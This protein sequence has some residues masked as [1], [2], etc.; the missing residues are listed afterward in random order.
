MYS[1]KTSYILIILFIMAGFLVSMCAHADVSL[2]AGAGQGKFEWCGGPGTGGDGCWKQPELPYTDHRD[3]TSYL[4]GARYSFSPYLSI[5]GLYHHFTP[6]R[7]SGTYV[8]D[9]DYN[10]KT[11]HVNPKADIWALSGQAGMQTRTDGISISVVP[12]APIGHFRVFGR[13]GTFI[14][15]QTTDFYYPPNVQPTLTQSGRKATWMIGSGIGYEFSR[16]TV[17]AEVMAFQEVK[18]KES[19]V[20]GDWNN[21]RGFGLVSYLVTFAYRL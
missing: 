9:K 4:F 1:T 7:V 14:Y 13:L 11:H 3:T 18:F 5:D 17:S 12:M 10:P 20:G 21:N 2:I 19:P 16:V 8:D 15:K 6:A